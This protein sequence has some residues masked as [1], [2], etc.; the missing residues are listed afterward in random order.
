M[1][2]VLL[3]WSVLIVARALGRA[4]LLIL[5]HKVYDL[6]LLVIHTLDSWVF[7]LGSL[8]LSIGSTALKAVAFPFEYLDNVRLP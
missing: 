2:Q 3:S 4:A 1:S 5:R 7:H 8:V 6:C